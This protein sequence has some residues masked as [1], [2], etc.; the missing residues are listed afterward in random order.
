MK[1]EKFLTTEDRAGWTTRLFRKM[2]LRGMARLHGASIHIHDP[3]GVW[4]LGQ[5]DAEMSVVVRFHDR[6]MWREVTLGG[7]LAAAEAYMEGRWSC[8]NL[9]L[10]TR[11]MGR[12]LEELN[13]RL[14]HP[15]KQLGAPLN[16]LAHFLNRNSREGSR[17][18]I[19]AHYDLGNDFFRLFLDKEH[20]M[21][22]SALYPNAEATLEE[23]SG[24]K[25]ER[26]CQK[27]DLQP[28]DHLLEIGTGW[29][30]MAI[31]AAKHYGCRVTTTTISRE[32]LQHAQKRVAEEGLED[33]VTL[34]FDDYRDL[35]GQYDKLVSIEMI[36]AVGHQY[37]P[38][39]LKTLEERLKPD[40]LALVQA[41]TVPDQR[42]KEALKQVDFI[43]K[44]IFPGG[45]L[46]SHRVLLEHLARQT[47][48]NLLHLEE[49]GDHYAR[50]LNDWRLRYLQELEAVKELGYD[51]RFVRMWEYYLCYCEGAFMERAIGTSQLLLARPGNRRANLVGQFKAAD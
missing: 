50:T 29:G 30:G 7:T 26:I 1:A 46:P 34:L 17:R 49:I 15:L 2:A 48:M 13:K 28:Q 42:Y 4:L 36:E 11:I 23:A 35:R 12:N 19:S 21:Y 51:Q 25:L 8:S 16:R 22:S 33:R 47:D 44:H 27:L 14:D 40:G 32:Q 10:L 39:Y 9:V 45:F 3:D 24:Y 41:I 37:L 31:Y 6:Q 5:P 20:K 18:N 38:I 43:K